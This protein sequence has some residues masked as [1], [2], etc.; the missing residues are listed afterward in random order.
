M[1]RLDTNSNFNDK[2]KQP[3][4]HFQTRL[5]PTVLFEYLVPFP[6]P[7]AVENSFTEKSAEPDP[8]RAEVQTAGPGNRA[9]AGADSEPP[10]AP[11]SVRAVPARRNRFR[12]DGRPGINVIKLFCCLS[13][14][15]M[16][17]KLQFFLWQTFP[18]FEP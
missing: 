11:A 5:H 1:F 3:L 9:A 12:R 2:K 14:T 6:D 7:V 10:S 4:K 8:E 17:N 18:V 13:P 15:K 16:P